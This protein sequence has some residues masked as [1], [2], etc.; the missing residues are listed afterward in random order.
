MANEHNKHKKLKEQNSSS[1]EVILD[2]YRIQ[3]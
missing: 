1:D 3:I 2:F